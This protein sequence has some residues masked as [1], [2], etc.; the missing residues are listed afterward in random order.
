MPPAEDN[1]N[2]LFLENGQE[3]SQNGEWVVLF[4]S[5]DVSG[6]T[7]AWSPYG[8]ETHCWK[9]CLLKRQM[10]RIA[11]HW[12]LIYF[13]IH[14]VSPSLYI[15]GLCSTA[16][17]VAVEFSFYPYPV[18][19]V[20]TAQASVACGLPSCEMISMYVVCIYWFLCCVLSSWFIFELEPPQTK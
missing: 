16:G 15:H 12:N 1:S 9:Y 6:G 11:V 7:L 5:V 14:S 18:V 13:S 8:K 2:I 17:R 10:V 19:P 3:L 20:K 4:A